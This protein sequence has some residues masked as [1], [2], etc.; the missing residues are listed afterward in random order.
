MGKS[1]F[2][3]KGSPMQRNFGIGSPAKKELPTVNVSGGNKTETGRAKFNR[4]K[5]TKGS[6]DAKIVKL[7][8]EYGGV[9]S[10]GKDKDGN[11]LFLNQDGKNAKEVSIEQ[12]LEKSQE[13]EDYI[14]ANTTEG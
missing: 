5:S 7:A 13:R 14:A 12:G 10:R 9:W 8:E 11:V 2:K 6:D 3:M 4:V 1:G